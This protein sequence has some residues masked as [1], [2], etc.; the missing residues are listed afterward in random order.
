[1]KSDDEGSPR[2]NKNRSPRTG[3]KLIENSLVHSP[4]AKGSPR[5]VSGEAYTFDEEEIFKFIV[6]NQDRNCD[7]AYEEI[8]YKGQRVDWQFELLTIPLAPK[9]PLARFARHG[10]NIFMSK[11]KPLFILAEQ[12][13]QQQT[14]TA[15][16]AQEYCWGIEEL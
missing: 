14:E 5:E 7:G 4:R 13:N 16:R 12:A 2:E 8:K 1:M 11:K 6:I 10:S 3:G 15:L 9:Y